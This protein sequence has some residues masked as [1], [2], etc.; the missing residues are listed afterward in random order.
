MTTFLKSVKRVSHVCAHVCPC[1][2]RQQQTFK[3]IES[4]STTFIR[5]QTHPG[6][7]LDAPHS[8]G[9]NTRYVLQAHSF[10]YNHVRYA[11]RPHSWG[12]H[13]PDTHLDHI[14]GVRRRARTGNNGVEEGAAR[15]L[16]RPN[17]IGHT[18]PRRLPVS[19][20]GTI[21]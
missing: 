20:R 17:G 7:H 14:H 3:H 19:V 18:P 13:T 9:T 4:S 6:T 16:R 5:V 1:A 8:W 21:G 10:G 12:T 2:F 15:R 11:P